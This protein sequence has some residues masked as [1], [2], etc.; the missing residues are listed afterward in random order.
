MTVKV[1]EDVVRSCLGFE[2]SRFSGKGTDFSDIVALEV[3]QVFVG[4]G[5]AQFVALDKSRLLVE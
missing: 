1:F 5:I 4:I 3:A 2:L